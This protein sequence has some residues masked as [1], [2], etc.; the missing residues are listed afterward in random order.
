MDW[1]AVPS[2]VCYGGEV[3][4]YSVRRFEPGRARGQAP[5]PNTWNFRGALDAAQFRH[6]S[7]LLVGACGFGS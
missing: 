5:L 4:K 6:G 3:L 7:E 1:A 2:N